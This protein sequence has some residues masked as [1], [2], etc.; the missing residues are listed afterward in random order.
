ML[1]GRYIVVNVRTQNKIKNRFYGTI[2]NFVRFIVRFFNKETKSYSTEI[3]RLSPKH[4]NMVYE[5]KESKNL[6]Y[7]SVQIPKWRNSQGD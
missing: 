7:F 5:S 2:R 1:P 3:N 6:P 4:L